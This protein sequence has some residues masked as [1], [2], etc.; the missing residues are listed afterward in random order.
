VEFYVKV[1]ATPETDGGGSGADPEEGAL[2]MD[3]DTV[4]GE[5]G[6]KR[7]PE[8]VSGPETG[9]MEA[10][11]D[12]EDNMKSATSKDARGGEKEKP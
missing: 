3:S 6:Q 12:A 11:V 9:Q 10:E 4:A 7:S 1:A 8:E 5:D 2:P